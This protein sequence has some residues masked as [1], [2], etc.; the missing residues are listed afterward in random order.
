MSESY[1]ENHLT[2]TVENFLILDGEMT[3]LQPAD[4]KKVE[5]AIDNFVN[6]T[7]YRNQETLGSMLK[8]LRK[9][10]KERKAERRSQCLL[11][12]VELLAYCDKHMVLEEHSFNSDIV[13]TWG[14]DGLE[15]KFYGLD[16]SAL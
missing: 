10:L 8:T 11:S 4:V 7:F 16:I 5:H 14:A 13:L 15:R 6:F 2:P 12:F 9:V 1:V 3:L